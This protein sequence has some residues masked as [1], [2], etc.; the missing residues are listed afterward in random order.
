MDGPRVGSGRVGSR[1][2]GILAGRVGFGHDFRGLGWVG[3]RNL[4]PLATLWLTNCPVS[5][6]LLAQFG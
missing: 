2:P 3:S 6:L 1:K 4:D 5:K